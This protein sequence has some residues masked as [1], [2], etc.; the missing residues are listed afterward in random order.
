[1]LGAT[2]IATQMRFVSNQTLE[3]RDNMLL[4][5]KMVTL[6]VLCAIYSNSEAHAQDCSQITKF[7]IFDL[8]NSANETKVFDSYL[9]YIDSRNFSSQEEASQFSS[10]LGIELPI[11]IPINISGSVSTASAKKSAYQKALKDL[12]SKNSSQYIKSQQAFST[13]NK[14]II[15]AWK[16]C[17]GIFSHQPISCWAEPS[18]SEKQLILKIQVRPDRNRFPILKLKST[19]VSNNLRVSVGVETAGRVLGVSTPTPILIDRV[20]PNANAGAI[21]TIAT[22]HADY[23][24]SLSLDPVPPPPPIPPI[25]PPPKTDP[26]VVTVVTNPPPQPDWF[27]KSGNNGTVSCAAYC[28]QSVW[29]QDVGVCISAFN[30][31][32]QILITCEETPGMLNAQLTCKCRRNTSFVKH[33][34][35][36][37]VSCKKFCAGG[38]FGE[39]GYC[40]S[41]FNTRTNTLVSCDTV[42][43]G[44][45]AEITCGCRK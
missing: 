41:A 5:T 31:R 42:V 6:G 40:L 34:N 7:G 26:V 13:A 3:M 25:P 23:S 22:H 24:C 33:G 8:S 20:G 16:Y 27:E 45:G 43:G 28:T 29:G 11:D 14:N 21:I 19:I 44:P 39:V 15:D 18:A 9:N 36:G 37:T 10:K 4:R 38:V 2:I 12:Q 1:M 35:N 17:V 30:T 32:D